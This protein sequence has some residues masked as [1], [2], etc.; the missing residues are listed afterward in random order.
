MEGFA[1][2]KVKTQKL[3][4]KTKITKTV[5]RKDGKVVFLVLTFNF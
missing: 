3:E 4:V 5:V 1:H 2:V